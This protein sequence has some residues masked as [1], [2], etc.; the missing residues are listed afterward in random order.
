MKSEYTWQTFVFA[1]LLLGLLSG[2]L[3]YFFANA[4]MGWVQAKRQTAAFADPTNVASAPV[5]NA[6]AYF[7]YYQIKATA[8]W[9]YHSE[10]GAIATFRDGSEEY[11]AKLPIAYLRKQLASAPAAQGRDFGDLQAVAVLKTT[12][13]PKDWRVFP[14]KPVK[15]S[16]SGKGTDDAYV[17][18]YLKEID[19][20]QAYP[21]ATPPIMVRYLR[22]NP[23]VTETGL[24]EL[25]PANYLK[26]IAIFLPLWLIPAFIFMRTLPFTGL[27]NLAAVAAFFGL[28]LITHGLQ[29]KA[30]LALTAGNNSDYGGGELQYL[31]GDLTPFQHGR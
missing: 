21:V 13:H 4:L 28:L 18:D 3:F 2:C 10:Y 7:R 8:G 20:L 16:P 30:L 26:A 5:A 25:S 12:L 11:T 22:S 19:T 17:N 14:Y 1:T 15:I 31:N 29:G 23:K 27:V 6:H 24:A 9:Q